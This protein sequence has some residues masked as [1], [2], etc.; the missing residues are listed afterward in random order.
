MRPAS[1][2]F[3]P[4]CAT[5]GTERGMGP[6]IPITTFTIVGLAAGTAIAILLIKARIKAPKWTPGWSVFPIGCAAAPIVGGL[7]VFI[8]YG[9]F[10]AFQPA[11]AAFENVFG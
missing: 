5:S 8:G 4:A 7:I 6:L 2:W 9:L 3:S 10:S 1:R 11:S